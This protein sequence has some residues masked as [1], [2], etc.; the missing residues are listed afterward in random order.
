MAVDAASITRSG[1]VNASGDVRALFLT[2]WS[3]ELLMQFERMNWI[4][5]I[6]PRKTLRGAKTTEWR[7]MGRI[8]AVFHATGND[9]F[10]DGEADAFN[11]V[12]RPV[13]LDDLLLAAT[14]VDELDEIRS[15]FDER[16]PYTMEL[17]NALARTYDVFGIRALIRGARTNITNSATLV[18]A[19]MTGGAGDGGFV[20]LVDL[21]GVGDTPAVRGGILLDALFAAQQLLDEKD[22]PEM[23]RFAPLKPV[24]YNYLT[25]NRELIDRDFGNEGNGVFFDG[26][27]FIGA[28]FGFIKTNNIPADDLTVNP[29]GANNTYT[30]DNTAVHTA[31]FHRSALGIVEAKPPTMEAEK[32][33]EKRGWGVISETVRGIAPVRYEAVV[34]ISSAASQ[35]AL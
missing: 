23:D 32:L 16:Q 5:R 12:K 24:H 10:E 3:G 18:P 34:E 28:G 29:T 25:R 35:P 19:D 6:F 14:F 7:A 21:A 9:V 2:T 27:V 20:G 8:P 15:E 33:F 31:T 1:R 4:D 17:A 13:T 30:G 11:H 26:T 22:V